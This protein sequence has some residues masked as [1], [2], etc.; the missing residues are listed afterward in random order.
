M[1]IVRVVKGNYGD[2][3][4]LYDIIILKYFSCNLYSLSLVHIP[5]HNPE[6]LLKQR[7]INTLYFPFL[8]F[9]TFTFLSKTY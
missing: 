2:N 4:H 7:Y 5:D 8:F 6:C 3:I 1:F 9:P